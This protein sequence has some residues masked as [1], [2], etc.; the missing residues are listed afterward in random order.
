MHKLLLYTTTY[1]LLLLSAKALSLNVNPV[2]ESTRRIGH[3]ESSSPSHPRHTHPLRNP[4]K[5]WIGELSYEWLSDTSNQGILNGIWSSPNLLGPNDGWFLDG[6]SGN[7]FQVT[8]YWDR[9]LYNSFSFSVPSDPDLNY[10]ILV[11]GRGTT[12]RQ[13]S[14]LG[15]VHSLYETGDGYVIAQVYSTGQ[16]RYNLTSGGIYTVYQAGWGSIGAGDSIYTIFVEPVPEPSTYAL[17]LGGTVFGYA[18]CRRRK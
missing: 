16:E 4:Y 10:S 11:S 2:P 7:Y 17:L 13:R 3:Y 9:H 5:Y 15:Y 6:P 12:I 18:F 1:L 14:Q 8:S